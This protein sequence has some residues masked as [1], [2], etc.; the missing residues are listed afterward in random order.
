MTINDICLAIFTLSW[1]LLVFL[2]PVVL[3]EMGNTL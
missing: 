1:Y 3:S 2:G